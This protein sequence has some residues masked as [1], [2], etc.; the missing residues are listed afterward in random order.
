MY[1][2][3]RL[4]RLKKSGNKFAIFNL[5]IGFTL[6]IVG[7][8]IF[9]AGYFI[10]SWSDIAIKYLTLPPPPTTTNSQ[11]YLII[12]NNGW[13]DEV[14]V[15]DRE[16]YS[17]AYKVNEKF[18]LRFHITTAL[19][20]NEFVMHIFNEESPANFET[21]IKSNLDANGVII[22]NALYRYQNDRITVYDFGKPTSSCDPNLNYTNGIS[23]NG[24]QCIYDYNGLIPLQFTIPGKYFA[25]FSMRTHDMIMEYRSPVSVFSIT[26]PRNDW[27]FNSTSQIVQGISRFHFENLGSIGWAWEGIGS[28]FVLS[29]VP[30]VLAASRDI[31]EIKRTKDDLIDDFQ[32]INDRLVAIIPKL[33]ETLSDLKKDGKI[34]DELLSRKIDPI[35]FMIQNLEI[36]SFNLWD[37]MIGGMGDLEKSERKRL[38][39]LHGFLIDSN[40]FLEPSDDSIAMALRRILTNESIKNDKKKTEMISFLVPILENNLHSYETQYARFCAELKNIPWMKIETWKKLTDQ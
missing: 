17:D 35:Q 23:K 39:T 36:M 33:K 7:T 16:P 6:I 2:H 30:I 8:L 24:E 12:P 3:K 27:L 10:T 19:P 15:I 5:A 37:S 26:D 34:I 22:Q 1:K 9:T 11:P 32:N 38:N 18:F 40:Q 28:G 29:G 25:D 14:Q 20:G 13:L 21:S 4:L 31:N